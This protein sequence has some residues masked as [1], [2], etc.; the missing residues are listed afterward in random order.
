VVVLS[1]IAILIGAIVL[2][3][4]FIEPNWIRIRRVQIRNT[5]LH[6]TIEHLR[7]VHLSDLH[8]NKIGY[9]EKKAIKFVNHLHPDMVFVT[10]DLAVFK[11]GFEPAV[12][13]LH[14]LKATQGIW[15]VLGNIDYCNDSGSYSSSHELNTQKLK[16]N[17]G[18]HFLCNSHETI[19]LPHRPNQS[20]NPADR[21]KDNNRVTIIGLDDPV[22]HKD[23]LAAAMHGAPDESAKIL[24]THYHKFTTNSDMNER[25]KSIDLIL[26]GHAHGGQIF[27][28]KYL[29]SFIIHWFFKGK[30]DE[31]NN[32]QKKANYRHVP[33]HFKGLYRQGETIGYVNRGFGTH[34]LPIRLG[35]RPE[36]TLLEFVAQ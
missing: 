19:S 20:P 34:F 30:S 24:L 25:S 18:I 10:G 15:V 27:I 9:R 22:T 35:V 14:K 29:P 3:A 11:Q 1:F 33:S 36:I 2:Y 21:S 32:G 13:F 31:E 12:N 26:S 16:D 5:R 23:D 6:R 28:L 4:V 17:D 7:A 8:I